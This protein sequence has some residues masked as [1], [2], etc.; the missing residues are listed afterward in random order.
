[1]IYLILLDPAGQPL[2]TASAESERTAQAREAQGFIRC[3][4][5]AWRV[6]RAALDLRT[7]ARLAREDE[8]ERELAELRRMVERANTVYP[9]KVG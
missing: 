7:K 6:A 1:M 4:P 8:R 2:A 9:K 5:D 3:T